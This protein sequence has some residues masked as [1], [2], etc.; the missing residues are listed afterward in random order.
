MPEGFEST[1]RVAGCDLGKSAAKFAIL[2][3]DG[4]GNVEIES[5]YEI[6]HDGHPLKA[7]MDWYRTNQVHMCAALGATGVYSDRLKAPVM[8]GLPEDACLA[9]ALDQICEIDGAINVVSIGARGYGA[10]VRN[11]HREIQYIENDKCSSGT[12]E[13]MVRIAGRFGMTIQEAD[14]A[15][16]ASEEVIPITARCSVFA[17]SEMTHFGNQGKP[18]PALF[19]GYF[20]S[21]AKY[22]AALLARI[23]VDGPVLVIGGCSRIGTILD[24]L[25]EHLQKEVV[26]PEL[27]LYAEALGAGSLAMEQ[28][29]GECLNELP[30]EPE[31]LIRELETRFV[32]LEPASKSRARVTRLKSRPVPEGAA[33]KPTVLGIDLG[34]TGSKIVLTDIETGEPVLDLYDRTR[35]N[36]VDAAQRLIA[37]LLKEVSPDIRG[38]ALTGSGREAAATVLRAA[39]PE[40][41]D[42]ILTLN[43]IV[44]HA[45]AAIRCDDKAGESLSIVEIGGQDAKFIQVLGGKIVESDMN[46]ACSAG[47]GSFLEE[48]ALFYGIDEITDFTRLA[49]S[50]ERPPDLGQMCTVFVADAAA[51]A[52]NEGYEVADLFSG[53]EHSVIHNYINRVMGQRTFGQRIFFQGKPATGE[54]LAWTLASI[55]GREV[56]VPPNPGAMGAWG[57][58]L[59]AID[60]MGRDSLLA[61]PAFDMAEALT[62]EVV[63]RSD[64][65]CKDKRCATLCSIERTTVSVQGN[66]QT[67]LSGGSCPR[68]EVASAAKHKLPVD[69]PSAFDE[70]ESLLAEILAEYTDEPVTSSRGES[71]IGIPAIGACVGWLPWLAT[72][73]HNLG[74][75]PTIMYPDSRTLARGEERCYSYD[76]C[77]PVKV[78]HGAL[79]ADLDRIFFPKILNV[80]DR[81]GCAGKTCAMEQALPE[82]IREALHARGREVEIISPILSLEDE[83]NTLRVRDEL[84]EITRRLGGSRTRLHEIARARRLAKE[85]QHAYEEGL[86]EIGRRTLEWGR[87]NDVQVVPVCGP[88]H[89]IH[90]PAVNAGIPRLLREN[91][92]LPLPME[93][94]PL[95]NEIVPELERVPWGDA[96]RALRVG[97]ASRMRGDA[98]PLLLSSFG[99]GPNSFVEQLFGAVMEGHPHTAL[100]SD[101]HGGT[102]GYTTRVQAFLYTV[103]RHDGS[104]SEVPA[105]RLA[106]FEQLPNPPASADRDDSAREYVIFAF[107]DWFSPMIAAAYRSQGINA[108]ASGPNNSDS[109]RYG[110]SDCSGKECLP[111]Q[112]MWGS[113]RRHLEEVRSDGDAE[114]QSVFVQVTGEGACRNCMFSIK[115]QLNLERLGM[116][117]RVVMRDLQIEPSLGLPFAHRLLMGLT[118]WDILLSLASYHRTLENE[119]GEVDAIYTEYCNQLEQIIEKRPG[120]NLIGGAFGI[121]EASRDVIALI[122]RASKTFAEIGRRADGRDDL[123]TV[124]LSGDIYLRLD[125]FAGDSIIR[126][127]NERGILVAVEPA[128]TFSSYMAYEQVRELTRIPKNRNRAKLISDATTFLRGNLY[129]R[130]RKDHPWMPTGDTEPIAGESR[131]HLDRY[132]IGEAPITIGSVMLHWKEQMCDG[133]VLVSPWGCGPALVAES[134]LRHQRDVPILFIYG[135]GS[136]IDERKLNS[137]VFKLKR[138]EP[139]VDRTRLVTAGV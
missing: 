45:T 60:E 96:L 77:A 78:G 58:G 99:C 89:V 32:T 113:F 119:P 35:G 49:M 12:G 65:Q 108:R 106:I 61:Q 122:D 98:Y 131:K 23:Q 50:A 44:A 74:F 75:R 94:F 115:D 51:E 135:D 138:S 71:E 14:Q 34:S 118:A 31:V 13:T 64:F 29:R 24:E 80:N 36:P 85:A 11:A 56:F 30:S 127:L 68:Y 137:F 38:I 128:L 72:F 54:S 87:E 10:L 4:S 26:V 91:G 129:G 39:F 5:T 130:V 18:A 66:V 47:T 25:G 53:F 19:R 8:T 46:K 70:R 55:T 73:T 132:P 76:A 2:A 110:R 41:V 114:R 28:A 100:E 20:G 101:G 79:D 43:E 93:C 102:A 21:I 62:A 81:D 107:S 124:L 116:R 37:A 105:E 83:M 103:S 59:C 88:L 86:A 82:M 52:R 104:P 3:I 15:A 27:A 92:A 6:E 112:L 42:R 123:R 67:V 95:D 16:R 9:A 126:R 136:P 109:L 7:F 133:A 33:E 48:Q 40:A 134:M 63:E 22:V 57:I 120:G 1:I 84:F 121:Y 69:A 125:E 97:I 111:Y 139:R 17:K 117:D 90:D